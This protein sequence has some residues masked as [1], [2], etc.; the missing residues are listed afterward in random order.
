MSVYDHTDLSPVLR[1]VT[2]IYQND[3]GTL[4]QITKGYNAENQY[5][6][7]EFFPVDPIN[8]GGLEP[9]LLITDVVGIET[10]AN[11]SDIWIDTSGAYI[12]FTATKLTI[13]KECFFSYYSSVGSETLTMEIFDGQ[14][15][16]YVNNPFEIVQFNNVSGS[17]IEI[18]ISN[19]VR[20]ETYTLLIGE[21]NNTTYTF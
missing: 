6:L 18:H 3:G 7:R 9:G 17:P 20:G 16:H 19:A 14:N 15:Y 10:Y 12:D 2:A 21:V 11:S 8:F 4:K 5:V 13:G 1:K